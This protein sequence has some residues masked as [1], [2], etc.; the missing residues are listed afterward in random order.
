MLNLLTL[1]QLINMSPLVQNIGFND[2]TLI[3]EPLR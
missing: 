1:K 2:L 3:T